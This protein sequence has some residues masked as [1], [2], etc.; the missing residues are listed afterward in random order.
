VTSG[1]SGFNPAAPDLVIVGH[2]TQ[3]VMPTGVRIGGVATYASAVAAQ[4][5]ASVGLVTRCATALDLSQLPPRLNLCRL[6][7]TLTTTMRHE[8]I[9]GR[10][11]QCVQTV[12]ETIGA[13]EAPTSWCDAPI[14]L[15]GP[16]LHEVEPA[17][18]LRFP[19]AIVGISAQ[20]WLRRVRSGGDIEEGHVEQLPT[21]DFEGRLSVLT[22]SDEDLAGQPIPGGWLQTFPT[23]IVTAA[24]R[25][26]RLWHDRRWWQLGAFPAAEL[27]PT[28]AGDALTA[29][30]LIRYWETGDVGAAV[31]FA[32]AAAS[33]IVEGPGIAAAAGRAQIEQR[34]RAHPEVQLSPG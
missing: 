3:D 5:D 14:L 18:V 4:L 11:R 1:A 26:L 30:F 34:L 15:L 8:Y 19:R 2:I 31:R 22:V 10:R 7:S 13:T 33:F 25:G 9:D 6:A 16:V 20:G 28:G 21:Q 24:E 12:A 27:E 17:V 32:A 23:V 29:A